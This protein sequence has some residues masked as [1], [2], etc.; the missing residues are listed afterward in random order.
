MEPVPKPTMEGAKVGVMKGPNDAVNFVKRHKGKPI[1]YNSFTL[2]QDALNKNEINGY[3]CDKYHHNW[4][5]KVVIDKELERDGKIS[6][7]W[8]GKMVE[9]PMEAST[10]SYYGMVIKDDMASF[11]FIKPLVKANISQLEN[12]FL[13][14]FE[15]KGN[16]VEARRKE[17]NNLRETVAFSINED[18]TKNI[19]IN[20]SCIV[21][22]I[23]LIVIV[24]EC[25]RQKRCNKV[26]RWKNG[27]FRR[28]CRVGENRVGE[29]QDS[30]L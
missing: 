22:A 28:L 9:T 2:L 11:L 17:I 7:K 6:G 26:L 3:I 18:W 21:A 16:I 4:L 8:Y 27:I 13:N 15:K 25:C 10:D 20:L 14:Y 29:T 30:D 19:L 1:T 12:R 5:E 24:Y 23:F